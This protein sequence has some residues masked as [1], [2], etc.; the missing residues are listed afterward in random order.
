[1][2]D[3]E[4]VE[5]V[6]IAQSLA[7]GV[8]GQRADLP[9]ERAEGSPQLQRAAG[10]V[11]VPERHLARL[12]GGRGDRDTFERDVLDPPR[13]RAEQERLAGATLVHH[14]LVE[15]AD[16]GAVGQE[17]AEETAIGDRAAAGD[18]EPL[19]PVAGPDHVVDTVPDDPR[20][21]FRE[22]LARIPAGQEVEDVRQQVVGQIVEIRTPPDQAR[23]RRRR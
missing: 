11:A 4:R 9:H 3:G 14:L 13:G 19:R 22:L 12:A 2:P 7:G 20:T 21:E 16:P 15:F 6:V 18:R 1:M 17:H 23:R 8:V 10:A 5:C